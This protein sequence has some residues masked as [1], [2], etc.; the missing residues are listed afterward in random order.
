MTDPVRPYV[1]VEIGVGW[2]GEQV[3]VSGDATRDE[4]VALLD[5]LAARSACS[6]R[7]MFTD[8]GDLLVPTS[9]NDATAVTDRRTSSEDRSVDD[10]TD[11]DH[12]R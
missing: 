11:G 12:V 10:Q 5:R 4:A 6:L 2:A 7:L 8:T 9:D 3:L 1:I